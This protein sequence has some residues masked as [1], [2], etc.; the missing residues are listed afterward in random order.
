MNAERFAA[1]VEAYGAEPRRWP[2]SERADAEAFAAR[3][4]ARSILADAR[5]LDVMLDATDAPA[6]VNLGFM[7]QALASAPKAPTPAVS[8]RPV[9]AMAACAVIGVALGFGGARQAADEQAAAAALE[10]A[11]GDGG[12]G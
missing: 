12:Q 6:P 2:E 8:W 10:I 9:A 4:E 7:R 3:P 1:I 5:A 11:F